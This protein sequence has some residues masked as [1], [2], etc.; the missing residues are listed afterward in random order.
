VAADTASLSGGVPTGAA[1]FAFIK[2]V[3][4]MGTSNVTY[5]ALLVGMW[6]TL[7]RA[8]LG[9]GGGG[10]GGG[11]GMGGMGMGGGGAASL[12]G[13]GLDSMLGALLGGGMGGGQYRGQTP[14]LSA[15]YGEPRWGRF[16][17]VGGCCDVRMMCAWGVAWERP[18][19]ADA[20]RLTPLLCPTPPPPC[21]AAF[22]LSFKFSI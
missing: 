11:G 15:N 7:Q 16:I 19:L 12:L 22:D 10:G 4:D 3:E 14:V 5:G 13:G 18:P 17:G 2:A 21:A 20:Y 6:Q 1:T 8:G 9:E